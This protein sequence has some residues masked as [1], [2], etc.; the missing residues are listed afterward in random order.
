ME[1]VWCNCLVSERTLACP[2]CLSCFCKAPAPYKDRFWTT[3][4][5]E[6]WDRKVA[7]HNARD[8]HPPQAPEDPAEV[9]HPLILVVDD[10]KHIQK[11]ATGAIQSLGYHVLVGRNGEEGLEMTLKYR[12]DLVLSD[13]MMPKLDGRE[14]CLRIK[15]NPETSGILV[16]IMTSLYTQG[17]YRSEAYKEFRVDGY[18]SKPIDLSQ[19]RALLQKHLG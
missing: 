7:E 5:Q 4:P 6:L 19:L 10:E 2:S 9:G 14:M 11:M 1:A 8:F 18:L 13:A 12:P 17:K 3:A 15:K 16:V